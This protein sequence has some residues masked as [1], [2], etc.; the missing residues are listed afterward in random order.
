MRV[1]KIGIEWEYRNYREIKS[2]EKTNKSKGIKEK[3]R[4][5]FLGVR[6]SWSVNLHRRSQT[7][8]RI[9]LKLGKRLLIQRKGVSS[10]NSRTKQW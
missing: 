2:K 3:E 9:N 1:V 7:K 5:R 10:V 6:S 8:G 4:K